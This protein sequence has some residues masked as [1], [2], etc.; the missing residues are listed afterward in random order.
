LREHA[1]SPG[2][3]SD[4]F[5][6]V[7]AKPLHPHYSQID[8]YLPKH[9]LALELGAGVGKGAIHLALKGLDVVAL[10]RDPKALEILRQTSPPGVHIETVA[11]EM[12]DF[13]PGP[14]DVVVAQFSLFF[15][16]PSEFTDLWPRLVEAIKPGGLFAGQLLGVND[17]WNDK[18]HSMHDGAGLDDLFTG[19]E[20]LY[21]DEVDRDGED[22]FKRPKHWHIF[23]IVA[24]K[25]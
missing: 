20:M 17:S 2:E 10:D 1:A 6:A 14:Y 13:P 9:G 16:A 5:K 24:R 11:A 7:L 3:W 15:L 25:K 12:R 4:Y 22:V 18:G 23:H 19:F 8:E 21:L